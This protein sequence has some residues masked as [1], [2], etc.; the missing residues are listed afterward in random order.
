MAI[1]FGIL[2]I[3]AA[4]RFDYGNDYMNYYTTY[5]QINT[6]EFSFSFKELA[7]IYREPGW[8]LFNMLFSPFGEAGFYIMVA[9]IA[10]FQNSVYYK[11]I[12]QY[13]PMKYRWFAVLIYLFNTS[14]YVLNMS[15]LRQGL[16]VTILLFCLP[17]I[18]EK[19]W[20]KTLIILFAF[21]TI[22]SSVTILL[23]FAFW[24]YL[25]FPSKK[26]WLIPAI[27]SVFFIIC[28]VSKDVIE[29]L[30]SIMT[31]I[32]E[33]QEYADIY[34]KDTNENSFKMGLGFIINSIPFIASLYY[35]AIPNNQSTDIK[36]IVALACIGTM[37][38]PF[39]QIAQMIT[40]I[41]IYFHAVS[42]V[43]IPIVYYTL[44]PHIRKCLIAIYIAIMSYS[45]WIFFHSP[46]WIDHY[47]YFKTIFSI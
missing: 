42:V 3:I 11:F 17:D 37:I 2:T 7:S 8:A 31:S 21:S 20:L 36:K 47:Y 6:Q 9:L 32:E 41:S 40:R 14:L 1:G 23:P 16:T 29:R 45:Y 38:A 34:I 18:L 30:F 15:M 28:I 12:K 43:S 44:R 27:Y 46:T 4:I 24:G 39:G 19:K 10:V 22:H 26:T 5:N 35:L 33:M 13:V 25:K